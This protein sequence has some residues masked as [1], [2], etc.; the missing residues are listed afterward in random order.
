LLDGMLGSLYE[1]GLN[2]LKQILE[3]ETGG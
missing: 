2:N 3:T 1:A